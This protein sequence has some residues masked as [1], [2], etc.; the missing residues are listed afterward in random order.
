MLPANHLC[1]KPHK[2]SNKPELRRKTTLPKVKS[3]ILIFINLE[4]PKVGI[5]HSFFKCLTRSQIH[6]LA[7]HYP[8]VSANPNACSPCIRACTNTKQ[9][10]ESM[11]QNL[12]NKRCDGQ[13]QV[14]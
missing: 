12:S 11:V 9:A 1:F 10:N 8:K 2:S 4:L 13:N 7:L 14:Y 5:L 6:M 3:E